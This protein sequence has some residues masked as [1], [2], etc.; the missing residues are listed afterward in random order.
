MIPP[1]NPLLHRGPLAMHRQM[2]PH[3]I[4]M[5]KKRRNALQRI[6]HHQK[7]TSDPLIKFGQYAI[8][9]GIMCLDCDD[10]VAAS[11]VVPIVPGFESRERLNEVPCH[12]RA[13]A[14]VGGGVRDL[15][16][17]RWGLGPCYF[18]AAVG[19]G[20]GEAAVGGGCFRGREDWWI[21]VDGWRDAISFVVILE[22]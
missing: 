6:P 7:R 12:A 19:K 5:I 22:R 16:V 8:A 10:L 2:I 4:N 13:A 9:L 11:V 1:P 21:G 15:N 17:G 3:L 14:R 18:A 20:D